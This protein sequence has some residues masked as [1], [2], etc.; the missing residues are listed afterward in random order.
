MDEH[1]VR[2]TGKIRKDKNVYSKE[3][4]TAPTFKDDYGRLINL[5]YVVFDFDNQPYIDIISKIIEKSNLKCKKLTTTR[6]VHYMFKTTLNNIINKS[7]EYNWLGLE[8]DIK[9]IGKQEQGKIAYQAIRVNGI[10]RQEEFINCSCDE[11]LDFAPTYLYH[12]KKTKDQK[13]L[14][15]DYS[16]RRND[17]FHR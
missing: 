6:G 13:D 14:T 3:Q 10:E 12:I 2:L 16:G 9:G 17:M 11:E 4:V 5:G 15:L 1:F 7:H 8:C